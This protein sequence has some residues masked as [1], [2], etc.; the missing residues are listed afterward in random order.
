MKEDVIQQ[1][2]KSKLALGKALKTTQ[3]NAIVIRNFGELNH[4]QGP[5]FSAAEIEID[6]VLHHGSVEIHVDSK[7]WFE[8]HHE[9]DE[10]YQSVVLHVVWKNSMDVFDLSGRFLPVL[11]LNQFFNEK[12]LQ[13]SQQ[14]L[15]L[16]GE[17]P[18]QLF[19][20][21]VL[22][23]E[24]YQQ[25]VFAQSKRWDRKIQDVLL[26]HHEFR[27]DWQ[28]VILVQVAKYWM[29]HQ[30]R[31]SMSLLV[32]DA[33]I[34]RLQKFNQTEMLA[35][36][37]GQ[38]QLSL[39]H[40][41]QNNERDLICSKFVFLKKK[42]EMNPIPLNWYFGRV[43]PNA[44]PDIR[45]WQWSKWISNQNASFSHWLQFKDYPELIHALSVG[46]EVK[47]PLK[48]EPEVMVNGLQHIHQLIINAIVPIWMAY[49]TLHENKVLLNQSLDILEQ[50]PPENN[51]ITK[52]MHWMN[53]LNTS[54]K[55]S[56]QLMGQYELYCSKKKC[57]ECLVGQSYLKSSFV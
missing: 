1:F 16:N 48:S 46:I 57:L 12:D 29:D 28:K 37:L 36:W 26:L 41:F 17:F 5:D 19:H 15:S 39:D 49:A 6:G 38:S 51:A 27:G 33:V 20:T 32:K 7:E 9:T 53:F 21:S 22:I 31:N 18:C 25:L 13:K 52:K 24:K 30:N 55:H 54:A 8:H 42:F 4:G 11:E 23:S 43:R 56:Q 44:F 3:N 50:I 2:W 40:L 45:L 14:I 47:R 35:F 10:K 34:S